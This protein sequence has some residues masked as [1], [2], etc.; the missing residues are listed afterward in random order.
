[1]LI[2][3]AIAGVSVLGIGLSDISFEN[4]SCEIQLFDVY[5]VDD[6]NYWA[7][8]ILYNN[9]DYVFDASL[10]YFDSITILNLKSDPLTDI[11]PGDTANLE[12][13][14]TGV[15]D[16]SVSMG[17]DIVNNDQTEFCIKEVQT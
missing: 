13:Q 8:M 1:M 3:V 6:D 15:L 5:Q 11:I 9:G 17:F 4:L 7:E 2:G 14:F 16:D 10:K 12:F